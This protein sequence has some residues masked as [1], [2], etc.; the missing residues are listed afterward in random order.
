MQHRVTHTPLTHSQR[1][2]QGHRDRTIRWK[3]VTGG[4]R[5]RLAVSLEHCAYEFV[6]SKAS[7]RCRVINMRQDRGSILPVHVQK[8]TR[9][10]SRFVE[11][12]RTLV[13]Y[14]HDTDLA[15]ASEVSV[16]GVPLAR[17]KHIKLRGRSPCAHT[18]THFG[19]MPKDR[20]RHI[21]WTVRPAVVGARNQTVESPWKAIR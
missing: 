6:L 14:I 9:N 4:V 10:A 15:V 20:G 12:S 1:R 7:Q 5:G 11:L 16:C 18:P 19:C 17:L 8:R 2:I 21:N 13:D 3:T